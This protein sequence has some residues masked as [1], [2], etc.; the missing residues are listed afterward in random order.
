MFVQHFKQVFNACVSSMGAIVAAARADQGSWSIDMRQ[1][2]KDIRIVPT[3]LDVQRDFQSPNKTR[4]LLREMR[5][6]SSLLL[7]LLF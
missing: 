4:L 5:G 7:Q 1:C 3:Q 6:Q 2:E